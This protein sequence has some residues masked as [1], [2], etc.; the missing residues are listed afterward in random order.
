MGSSYFTLL[1]SEELEEVK[2][3]HYTTIFRDQA[4]VVA[5]LRMKHKDPCRGY[6]LCSMVCE[7]LS[8]SCTTL[9]V[10]GMSSLAQSARVFWL[11]VFLAP[12]RVQR[13]CTSPR[14][15]KK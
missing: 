13:Q 4:A 10:N 5:Y 6:V 1:H 15:P 2:D 3:L 9:F 7:T 8:L 14:L 12:S 11:L